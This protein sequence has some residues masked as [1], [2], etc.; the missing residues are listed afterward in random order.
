MIYSPKERCQE[1]FQKGHSLFSISVMT[2]IDLVIVTK[3]V[4]PN[5]KRKGGMN[6][7]QILR[8]LLKSTTYF[9]RYY[10]YT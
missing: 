5:R 8:Y 2:G 1:L 3:F 10:E 4:Q 6:R 9:K 7:K